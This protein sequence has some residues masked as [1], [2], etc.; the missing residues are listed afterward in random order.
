MEYAADFHENRSQPGAALWSEPLNIENKL[1]GDEAED[2]LAIYT[3]SFGGGRERRR[4]S[5]GEWAGRIYYGTALK[6]G[7]TAQYKET[8]LL[9]K[10]VWT[11]NVPSKMCGLSK[12]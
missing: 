5:S 11:I 8:V 4:Q 12:F 1:L 3:S 9:Q 6:R 2:T 7:G 10:S